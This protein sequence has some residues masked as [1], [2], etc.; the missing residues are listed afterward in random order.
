M[1]HS[2]SPTRKVKLQ[3]YEQIK[4]EWRKQNTECCVPGCAKKADKNPHHV[5]GR[6]FDLLCACVYWKPVCLPHHTQ[7]KED[8]LWA[9]E[10]GLAPPKGC[11][12]SW[13]RP[14]IMNEMLSRPVW[15]N[16]PMICVQTNLPA[17]PT[18]K[19]LRAAHERFSPSV[20]IFKEFEC[21]A[22]RH[23]HNIGTGPDPGG[24]SSGTG[25]TPKINRFIYLNERMTRFGFRLIL[26]NPLSQLICPE[27]RCKK[28]FSPAVLPPADSTACPGCRK[29]F[30]L[31]G[32][33]WLLN[34]I[35]Q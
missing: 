27:K 16:G 7:V 8:P 13:P 30:E 34:S 28:A 31:P 1:I 24:Q 29:V 5:F 23:W 4:R 22:C 9:R 33:Y 3:Q 35:W 2:I 15:R 20:T 12:N 17:Y 6:I 32:D 18:Q 19:D 14:D 26:N 11:Y 21:P 10:M 25:R